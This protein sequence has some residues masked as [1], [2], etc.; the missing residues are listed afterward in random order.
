MYQ[1][2]S[3]GHLERLQCIS[4]GKCDSEWYSWLSA[5]NRTHIT[6]V[7]IFPV[8][9]QKFI[10]AD[11][12]SGQQFYTGWVIPRVKIS[13]MNGITAIQDISEEIGA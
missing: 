4:V 2:M 5:T 1:E 13:G 6:L 9:K 10:L 11:H 7:G 8:R 12:L 3:Y